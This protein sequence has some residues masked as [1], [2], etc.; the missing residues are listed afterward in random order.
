MGVK[1]GLRRLGLAVATVLCCW[2]ASAQATF[3]GENG[4]IAFRAATAAGTGIHAIDPDGG[5]LELLIPEGSG[6]AWSASGRRIAYSSTDGVYVADQDG[7]GQTHVRE[8]VVVR[9]HESLVETIEFYEPTWAPDGTKIAYT[10][11]D[12]LCIQRL[13]CFEEALGIRAM[14]PDGSKDHLLIDAFAADAA[15]SPDGARI[16][17][18]DHHTVIPPALHV[19]NADGT[20]D[21]VLVAA[22]E[23]ASPASASWSPDGTRIA[24]ARRVGTTGGQAEIFVMNA[25]GSDQTRLTFDGAN[26][27]PVWSPDGTKIAWIRS[28]HVWVM[29]P[30][31]SGQTMLTSQPMLMT[32]LDWQPV[33]GPRREDFRNAAH[34]CKALREHLGEQEFRQTYRNHGGC[35]S[36][37]NVP[38]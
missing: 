7:S 9:S 31:G 34:F 38:R 28:R 20:D 27:S 23:Q 2:P 14:A 4:K 18:L 8:R 6:P 36:R 30:D 15:Y 29:N 25:D 13:G 24:F 21:T 22:S 17:W 5:G 10:A 11:V 26:G 35:V 16:A 3:P 37:S 19:S 32:G 12:L 1:Q 33:P